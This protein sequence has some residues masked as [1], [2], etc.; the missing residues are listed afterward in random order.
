MRAWKEAS[1]AAKEEVNNAAS[2]FSQRV[3]ER[4]VKKIKE[5]VLQKLSTTTIVSI[6]LLAHDTGWSWLYS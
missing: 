1:V 2:K 3:T 6:L 4:T 5:R